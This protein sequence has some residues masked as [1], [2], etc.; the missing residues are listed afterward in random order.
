MTINNNISV[1]PFYTNINEQN[2]RKSY[3]YGAVYPLFSQAGMLLPFQIIRPLRSYHSNFVG[4][5][6]PD[7]TMVADLTQ[8]MI[9][10]GLQVVTFEE[11]GYEIVL[12]PAI[13]PLS[14]LTMLDG[15][16]Y[17]TYY[18]YHD[19]WYSEIFTVVQDVSPYLKIEWYNDKNLVFDGGQFIFNNPRFHNYLY[20]ATEVGKPEYTF[21][22]EGENRDGFFFPEKQLSEKRYKCTI[23]APEYLCDVM[24]L[25]RMCD[26]VRITDKY[27]RIYDCDQFLIT[28]EWQDQGDLA[29]VEIEFETDTVVKKIGSGR[30]VAQRG[31]FNE[32]YS[33][34]F[35]IETT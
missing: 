2:H 14:Q 26:H 10:T 24:R 9:E 6:R 11:L 20:F 28:P 3:A 22:E 8:A 7:G 1:L 16:Y 35:L 27:G 15:Q 21:E 18:D 19:T 25:I 32:D 31:D 29:S 13:F 5:F 12:Y 33:D 30:T 4:L 17:L 23:L 34:D